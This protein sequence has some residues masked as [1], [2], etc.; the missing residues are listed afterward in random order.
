MSGWGKDKTL[1]KYL[2][3]IYVDMCKKDGIILKTTLIG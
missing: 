3:S 2:Q 1:V